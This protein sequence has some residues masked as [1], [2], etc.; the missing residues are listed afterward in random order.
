MN[1]RRIFVAYG[2]SVACVSAIGG[3]SFHQLGRAPL[4]PRPLLGLQGPPRSVRSPSS[5]GSVCSGGG[6]DGRR[7]VRPRCA[8]RRG[9]VRVAVCR[10][11]VR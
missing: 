3:R 4:P 2:P 6:G 1:T 8:V 11:C 7:G 9:R 5:P 10:R